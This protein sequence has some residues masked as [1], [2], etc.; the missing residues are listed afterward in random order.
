[1][2]EGDWEG[3]ETGRARAASGVLGGRAGPGL[4]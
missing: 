1:M 4:R 3:G 2:M